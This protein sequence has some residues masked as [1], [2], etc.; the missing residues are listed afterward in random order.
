MHADK[1]GG[2]NEGRPAS[3]KVQWLVIYFKK[4]RLLYRRGALCVEGVIGIFLLQR[5]AHTLNHSV[6]A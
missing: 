6:F 1:R 3:A 5:S 4:Y 2:S